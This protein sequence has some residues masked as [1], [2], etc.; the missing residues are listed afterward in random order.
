MPNIII[1]GALANKPFN[2]GN[3]WSRLS[4]LLGFKRLGFDVCF[5]EQIGRDNCVDETGT[6][7]SFK[8]SVNLAYF[9]ATMAQFG[10]THSCVLIYRDG[11][12][13]DGLSLDQLTEL[14]RNAR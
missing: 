1:S 12:E 9:K 8:S 6:L 3:A 10:L 13:V 5:V 7:S 14:V 2:G 4:W 11:Q